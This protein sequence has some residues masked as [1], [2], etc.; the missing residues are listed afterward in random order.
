M[1]V[2]KN[3]AYDLLRD[4]ADRHRALS[5]KQTAAGDEIVGLSDHYPADLP[6]ALDLVKR[7][8]TRAP[9]A[10]TAL[11]ATS[12]RGHTIWMIE[13]Q[14]RSKEKDFSHAAV[15][16]GGSR[17]A[18][19]RGAAQWP[20][21]RIVD[22]AGSERI[23][24]S[25]SHTNETM[26]INMDITKL[27]TCFNQVEA[28]SQ[29]VS[30]RG[31]IITRLL[32][33]MLV[34][35]ADTGYPGNRLGWRGSGSGAGEEGGGAKTAFFSS[36][37]HRSC[38]MIINVNP[39]ASEYSETEKV[40][41]NALI[42]SKARP[43]EERALSGGAGSSMYG[44]D[45]H[46]IKRQKSSY[47]ALGAG[48]SSTLS[49]CNTKC[50]E[51]RRGAVRSK[52]GSSASAAPVATSQ[53]EHTDVIEDQAR[54]I[55]RLENEVSKMQEDLDMMQEVVWNEAQHDIQQELFPLISELEVSSE[56]VTTPDA[57]EAVSCTEY[58][59]GACLC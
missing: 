49:F 34:R 51:G 9:V 48:S 23:K 11:N 25:L 57:Q 35:S 36:S 19:R 37:M 40:L 59:A 42:S 10:A 7:A 41:L 29:H 54:E 28:G 4:S 30:W 26:H 14:Q 56:L 6:A 31:R 43:V 18:T 38:I 45:G 58:V 53:D 21:L 44:M 39:A 22:L 32:K 15:G 5:F 20:M 1:E 33:S 16:V 46:L 52:A 2:Y 55:A 13:L 12:S 17:P 27:F 8:Q 47:H 50:E 24:R 3:K